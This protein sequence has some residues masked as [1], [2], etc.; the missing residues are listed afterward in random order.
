M[1]SL[2]S[3]GAFCSRIQTNKTKNPSDLAKLGVV[4]ETFGERCGAADPSVETDVT[5]WSGGHGSPNVGSM[6]RL[7]RPEVIL[8][9]ESD[10]DGLLA[11][12]L[13]QRLCRAWFDADVPLVAYHTHAWRQRQ[14]FETAAWVC[15]FAFEPRLDRP[16]WVV[17]DHHPF[18]E[19]PQQARLLHD[20]EKSAATLVY[21]L[22]QADKLGSEKLDRLVHLSNVADLFLTDDPDFHL[23]LDHA[24]LI[25]TYGF[26]N[27]VQLIEGDPERLLNHAL[28]QVTKL[29]R[30]VEDPIGLAWS[31]EHI[32]ALPSGVGLVETVVGNPNLIVHELLK[33]SS[34]PYTVLMTLYRRGPGTYLASLRSRNGEALQIAEQLKGGGHPNASG[35][36]LPRSAQSIADAVA[37]LSQILAPVPPPTQPKRESVKDLFTGA[38]F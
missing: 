8:T 27:L 23:A 28:L 17:I 2:D 24:S 36:I 13:C 35:A 7:P 33:D 12:L 9:H 4:P 15:D 6:S 11:G 21:E 1:Y 22:C 26:W 30:E 38:G 25:K 29:K 16:N 14:Q 32:T 31:R 10:L 20:H 3:G 34:L 5:G 19:G 18:G 37:Y